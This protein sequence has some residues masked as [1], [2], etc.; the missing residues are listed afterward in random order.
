M[1]GYPGS[2]KTTASKII[3]EITN[4]T[5]LWADQVRREHIQNPTYSSTENSE[6]YKELNRQTGK[7]LSQGQ[8]VVFDTNF[9]FY[10]DREHLREIADQHNADCKLVWI[11]VPK[12]TAKTRSVDEAHLHSTR[13]L[14]AMPESQFDRLSR[15]LQLPKEDENPVIFDGTKL[16]KEYVAQQLKLK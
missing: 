2:G 10:H 15:S 13:V 11:Q 4:A 6:L 5:H 1:M 9:N 12:A 3:A 14:G 16:T 8:S 7:L